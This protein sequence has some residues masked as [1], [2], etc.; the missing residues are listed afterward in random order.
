ME[1]PRR[2]LATSLDL[3]ELF[4]D[5]SPKE[6]CSFQG[7]AFDVYYRGYKWLKVTDLM[8]FN[9]GLLIDP[10][11]EVGDFVVGDFVKVWLSD[12]LGI[13]LFVRARTEQQTAEDDLDAYFEIHATNSWLARRRLEGPL[14]GA[15]LR[16]SKNYQFVEM[17][18]DSVE[19]GPLERPPEETVA[20]LCVLIDALSAL[21]NDWHDDDLDE[22]DLGP[23]APFCFYCGFT[24]RPETSVCPRCD[25]R[26]DQ[27]SDEIQTPDLS[28]AC[29][30]RRPS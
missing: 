30:R 4:C 8:P 7:I 21:D 29:H 3:T 19:F 9:M 23:D 5:F 13:D 17:R 15:L 26:L 12:P 24:V 16:L 6:L 10:H 20:D 25:G 1:P 28:T 2:D 18:D 22:P 11:P 14:S 27:D